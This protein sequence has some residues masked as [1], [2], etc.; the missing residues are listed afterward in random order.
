MGQA[1]IGLREHFRRLL[2]FRGREDRASFWPYAALAFGII[3]IVGMVIF[4][5]MMG[6]S[7]RAMQDYASQ[8][9]EQATIMSGPGQYSISVEGHHPEFFDTGWMATY[10]AVTFGLAVLLYAA[11]V[12]RRLHDRGKSGAWGLMPLPFILYSSIMMPRMF[13]SFGTGAEPSMGLFFSIFFS[14]M[15]YM[16]TLIFLIVLLAGASEPAPN[17]YDAIA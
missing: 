12:V 15:L 9:P 4:V 5:P 8:H 10:L 13:A 11:A 3:M 17:R 14:N 16:A 1:K 6:R 2:D 7:M